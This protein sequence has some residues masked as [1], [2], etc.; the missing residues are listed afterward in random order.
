MHL[1]LS[2]YFFLVAASVEVLS[3]TPRATVDD[4][5]GNVNITQMVLQVA[6]AIST[7]NCNATTYCIQLTTEQIPS[8][9]K[10]LGTAGCW[11]SNSSPIHYCAVCMS[12]PTDNTTTPDQTQAAIEGHQNY[13]VGCTAYQAFLNGTS[14]TTTSSSATSSSSS[15]SSSSPASTTPI[16]VATGQK[17]VS[18]GTIGGV[19]VGGLVGLALIIAT[20]FLLYRYM[21]NKHERIVGS[22][23]RGS[24]YSGSM[25]TNPKTSPGPVQ[26]SSPVGGENIPY[27]TRILYQS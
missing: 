5:W 7:P 15:S 24:I 13:H 25:Q 20:V 19:V 6:N 26:A 16:Q 1:A 12:N 9:L 4:I 21:Q 3:F 14:S 22:T 8:C 18:A 27:D 10:V 17:S 11:C 2:L 23:L